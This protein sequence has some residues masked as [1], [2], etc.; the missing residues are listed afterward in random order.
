MTQ[1]E[2]DNLLE[3]AKRRYPVGCTYISL[4]INGDPN[5]L[6]WTPTK[7]SPFWFDN[8]RIAVQE[9]Q[10][11]VYSNGKWAEIVSKPEEK[12]QFEVGK[13][14]KIF[15]L[16][17]KEYYYAKFESYESNSY[18]WTEWVRV[19]DCGHFKDC[20][21]TESELGE[22]YLVKDLSEIQP[23]LPDGHPD[24]IKPDEE[25]VVHVHNPRTG[26]CDC[27]HK[28]EEKSEKPKSLV[29]RYLRYVGKNTIGLPKFG[30]YFKITT[31]ECGNNLLRLSDKAPNC[32]WSGTKSLLN[33][34]GN[35]SFELMPEGF[36]PEQEV[37]KDVPEYVMCLHDYKDQFTKGRIYKVLELG[38][39]VYYIKEDDLGKENGWDKSYFLPA[40][41][42]AYEAQWEV[43]APVTSNSTCYKYEIGQLV[44]VTK[45]RSKDY[46]G[47][48]F[49]NQKYDRFDRILGVCAYQGNINSRIIRNNIN[50]YQLNGWT[51][52]SFVREDL[53][54]AVFVSDEIKKAQIN[55]SYRAGAEA[56]TA[57]IKKNKKHLEPSKESLDTIKITLKQP[58]SII[59]F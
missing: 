29:G 43:E 21:F 41:K 14:Y 22:Y 2:K 58:K 24:K 10:G 13:W 33:E 1:E 31:D 47:T 4:N 55:P 48:G 36:N 54:D 51:E 52:G 9:C 16:W 45:D 3:E 17:N 30:D 42:K 57:A 7:V 18:T 12:P 40:S 46:Q 50:Y 25:C 20:S 44:R 6:K 8:R 56:L 5:G 28:T 26:K 39:S 53:L 49:Y 38:D 59:K 37:V 32:Y 19:K 34:R 27:G 35:E 15:W 11:I 23:Y